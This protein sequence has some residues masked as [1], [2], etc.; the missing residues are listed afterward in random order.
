MEYTG[1][2]LSHVAR[3]V[4]DNRVTDDTSGF[5]AKLT[6]MKPGVISPAVWNLVLALLGAAVAGAAQAGLIPDPGLTNIA[7]LLGA[8]MIGQSRKRAGDVNA[9]KLPAV[10]STVLDSILAKAMPSAPPPVPQHLKQDRAP[11]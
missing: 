11:E 3:F 7:S 9:E 6:V 8:Y 10:V 4:S 1:E 5:T 2:A